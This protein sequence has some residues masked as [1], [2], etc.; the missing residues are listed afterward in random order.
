MKLTQL[1]C[2]VDDFCRT[3]IPAWQEKQLTNGGRKRNRAHRMSDSE[4]I[5][6]F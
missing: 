6:G 5:P 3:F 2:D 1:F 4:M